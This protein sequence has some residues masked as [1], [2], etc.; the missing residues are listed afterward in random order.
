M[1]S[2]FHSAVR[3]E[4]EAG[5]GVRLR[6]L[7]T[8]LDLEI[9]AWPEPPQGE[10]WDS[11]LALGLF[12]E[13]PLDALLARQRRLRRELHRLRRDE[14]LLEA[15]A[16]ARDAAAYYRQRPD[17]YPALAEAADLTCY[18]VLTRQDLRLHG[19]DF[20]TE[21]G[22]L[23][24]RLADG[25]L[26]IA[27][28]SGTGG[29]RVQVW[30]DMEISR[31]PP[32]PEAV[33]GV[34]IDL[35]TARTAV[36]T[37]P[38]CSPSECR[39]GR[40]PLQER[41]QFGSTLYLNST[42]DLFG[43]PDD[44]VRN[45]CDEVAAFRPDI[46]LVNPVYL[47]RVLRRVDALGLAFPSPRLVL[48]SYQYCS[49]LQRR[50]LER[51]LGVPVRD[52]YAATELAGS[53]IGAQCQYG[54]L[55]VREDHVHLEVVEEAGSGL[56]AGVGRLLVTT[57]NPSFP[58]LR[59]DVGDIAR[60]AQR[61]CPCGIGDWAVIELHGRAGE[62]ARIGGRRLTTREVDDVMAAFEGIDFYRL[63]VAQDE[64]RLSIV[65]APDAESDMADVAADVLT[66]LGLARLRLDVVGRLVP[67]P[68]RKFPF[69]CEGTPS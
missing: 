13:L 8:G 23:A 68:S 29:E 18:P 16:T 57:G 35:A 6:D 21:P 47:H 19:P 50:F 27:R 38:V 63:D 40:A 32:D 24:R 34:E 3:V 41:V 1:T 37:S 4:R 56:P 2:P 49:A 9:D 53:M 46:L 42:E 51:R 48:T 62:T 66:T 12:E 36:L 5:P 10:L 60:L 65:P 45:I 31:L 25:S 59:Y 39:L 26:Q 33:W 69:L 67:A 11:L 14:E 15:V 61:D 58:L 7:R 55:H 54:H 20:L 22:A 28:T 30:S 64:G 43:A 52:L 17:A 44:L